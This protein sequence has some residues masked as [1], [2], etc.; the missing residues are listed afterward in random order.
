MSATKDE[1]TTDRCVSSKEE[2]LAKQKN[3]ASKRK[4]FYHK[5]NQA[6]TIM[7]KK[8]QLEIVVFGGAVRDSNIM[9]KSGFTEW[10]MGKTDIDIRFNILREPIRMTI[11][12]TVQEL[13][14]N[15][16][17]L[18]QFIDCKTKEISNTQKGYSYNH[19]CLRTLSVE[20]QD[21][22]I[23]IDLVY[24]STIPIDFNVNSL[25]MNP[26]NGITVKEG[27][28]PKFCE[29]IDHIRNRIFLV[30]WSPDHDLKKIVLRIGKMESRG[31]KCLNFNEIFKFL[32]LPNLKKNLLL[33]LKKFVTNTKI[34]DQVKNFRDLDDCGICKYK[35]K[36]GAIIPTMQCS[37]NEMFHHRCL[38]SYFISKTDGKYN[39][40]FCFEP[41]F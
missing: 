10:E 7:E 36:S 26:T 31:W 35:V 24:G 22:T 11:E 38:L 23:E 29:I 15:F 12:D 2:F 30:L 6:I 3:I 28:G 21:I 34:R 41:A 16:V 39:C 14:K 37:H 13:F 8:D 18:M 5:I 1:A 17:Q 40:P 19:F 33:S 9:L 4:S 32:Q 25:V 27:Y 20:F